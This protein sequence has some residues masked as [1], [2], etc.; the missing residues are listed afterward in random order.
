MRKA[1]FAFPAKLR[2]KSAIKTQLLKKKRITKPSTVLIPAAITAVNV[3]SIVAVIVTVARA[4]AG[5]AAVAVAV[6]VISE[7]VD[8]IAVRALIADQASIGAV[9]TIG[10]DPVVNLVPSAA[11]SRAKAANNANTHL[12]RWINQARIQITG[13][14]NSARLFVFQQ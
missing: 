13:A 5:T 4:A 2:W 12:V 1:A 8:A 14:L 7:A 11:V 10:A 3:V 9:V 6:V